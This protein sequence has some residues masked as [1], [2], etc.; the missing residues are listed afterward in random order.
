M[1]DL[2]H[3]RPN[4]QALSDLIKYTLGVDAFFVDRN[5]IAVAGTGLYR[6]NIGTRRPRDSYVDVTLNRGDGQIVTEPKYT[7]QCYRCE[8]RRL[9]PYSMVMCRPIV[10]GGSVMGLIGF[11][12]FS[13][14]QRRT[15]V[16]RAGLLHA[17]SQKLDYIWGTEGLDVKSFLGLPQTRTLLD[18]FDEGLILTTPENEILNLN[19]QG[20]YLLDKD[21]PPAVRAGDWLNRKTSGPAVGGPE[22]RPE[23]GRFHFGAF[24]LAE[25]ERLVSRL[26]VV[27]DRKTPPRTWKGCPLT[28]PVA[29][30]I[31]GASAAMVQI[32][33]Q[34]ACVAESDSTVLVMGETGVGKE[35]V[36]RFIHQT[37]PRRSGVFQTVNCAAIPDTLF[38]SELFGYAPGAFTGASRKG[39]AG[40]F[41][42]ADGGTIFLDEVGRLSLANQAK[43]LRVLEEGLVQRLGEEKSEPVDVRILAATNINLEKA[44]ASNNFL[45]DL[46]YRLMVIPLPI[47]PLRDRAED[48]PLLIE[49]FTRLFRENLPLGGFHGFNPE[50]LDYLMTYDWPGNVREL[51]N[52]VEYV[53]TL[54]RGRKV[55][56]EDLP[57]NIRRRREEA[58]QPPAA[59][60]GLLPLAA[61]ERKQVL[62]ALKIYGHTTEG[63]RRAASHLGI[64]LSTLY[65]KLGQWKSPSP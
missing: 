53:M 33:Q 3:H 65:R 31:I 62:G 37:G 6:T 9:C 48:I 36:A 54:V 50:T 23:A 2:N 14:E 15:M 8:Y 4:L 25:D 18:T 60:E 20:A 52:M 16:E 41:Q 35:L 22:L 11:L 32:K 30:T 21:R 47:P 5:M 39:R 55:T 51:K 24:P 28:T 57:L 46:Y 42:M 12:G 34:A 43:I 26:F 19:Q 7:P 63:K 10:H 58:G 17:L 40:K 45:P 59:T 38:E 61:L 64:S 44:V 29:E 49:H 27:S 13:E 56:L 1:S